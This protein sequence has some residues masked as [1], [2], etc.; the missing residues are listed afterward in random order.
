M[1]TD[2]KH[3]PEPIHPVLVEVTRGPIVESVHFG[4][5]NGLGATRGRRPRRHDVQLERRA[6]D[7]LVV[8]RVA[9]G[10]RARGKGDPGRERER[11]AGA[12]ARGRVYR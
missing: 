6:E 11:H 7:V 4:E 5:R 3:N 2:P 9:P 12:V 1:H 8:V 10:A